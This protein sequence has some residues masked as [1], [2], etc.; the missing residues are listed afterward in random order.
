MTLQAQ[1]EAAREAAEG[2]CEDLC[3]IVDISS[4][5]DGFGGHAQTRTNLATGVPCIIESRAM[6]EAAVSAGTIA[7]LVRTKIYMQVTSI[8]QAIRPDYEI[9]VA[10]RD[11][12][13]A[14]TFE[15][16]RRLDQ[17]YEVL[18]TVSAKLRI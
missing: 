13:A 6:M 18:V 3:T 10:A 9:V 12:K 1:V 14:L 8:T 11:G 7:S 16:P 2:L 4:T 15:D 17:S 5:P